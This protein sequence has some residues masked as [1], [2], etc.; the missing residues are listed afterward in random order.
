MAF[1][2]PSSSKEYQTQDKVIRR[3]LWLNGYFHHG[4]S[5]P[6]FGSTSGILPPIE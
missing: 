2:Q 1:R 5:R 6:F 4:A 3:E